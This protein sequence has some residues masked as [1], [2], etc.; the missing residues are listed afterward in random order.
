MITLDKVKILVQEYQVK[1]RNPSQEPFDY[2]EHCDLI[3]EN[4]EC[5]KLAA[6]KGVYVIM[7]DDYVLYIGKSSAQRKAIWHR[8][9]DHIYSSRPSSWA[10]EAT[11]F[12]GWAVP[13]DSFFEASALEEFLIFKLGNN[14]PN[15]RV[16]K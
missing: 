5:P 13:D 14:L 4:P 1:Y 3:T 7:K 9:F 8:I 15:N 2:I 11:S 6:R 16:G 10:N 12:V